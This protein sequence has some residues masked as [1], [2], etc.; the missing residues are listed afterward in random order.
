M[1]SDWTIAA[2]GISGTIRKEGQF[3][4]LKWDNLLKNPVIISK[5][6]QFAQLRIMHLGT[7]SMEIKFVQFSHSR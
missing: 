5:F 4:R 6:S 2:L 1:G 3:V 7:L